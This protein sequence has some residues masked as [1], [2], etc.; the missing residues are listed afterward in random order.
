MP[1]ETLPLRIETLNACKSGNLDKLKQVLASWDI[2]QGSSPIQAA[3]WGAPSRLE[4]L[5]YTWEMMVAAINANQ[6]A[7]VAYIL[8]TFPSLQVQDTILESSLRPPKPLI[9]DILLKHD[10]KI[11]NFEFQ[12]MYTPLIASCRG[13]DPDFGVYLLEQGAD[14][15]IGG[16]GPWSALYYAIK[17]KQPLRLIKKLLDCGANMRD[18]FAL[19]EAVTNGLVEV[20]AAFLDSGL[21]VNVSDI[22]GLDGN[23]LYCAVRNEQIELSRFLLE[24]GADQHC[25]DSSGKSAVEALESSSQQLKDVFS[26]QG[27]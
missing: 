9:F 15:N 25:L 27:H 20:L 1:S 3:E 12:D 22:E 17:Y 24:H 14:P 23:L 13:K 10:P 21:D 4:D 6:T 26:S 16:M 7:I 18:R 2:K 5:P 8:K 11:I 19:E